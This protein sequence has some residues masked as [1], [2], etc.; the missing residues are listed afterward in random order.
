MTARVASI[1]ALGPLRATCGRAAV[2]ALA[3][4]AACGG[5]GGGSGGGTTLLPPLDPTYRASGKASAGDVFV[6]L[7]EWRWADIARECETFLGPVGYAAVQISP[8]SEHAVITSGVGYP[9]W[10]RYQTVSYKL[11]QS[12]SGTLAEFRDMVSRCNAAGVKIY[13]DAV[14]NHMTAGAGVGSAGSSYTKT[15]YPAVPWSAADFHPGCG[16]NQLRRRRE[17]A[18]VRTRRAGRSAH[19]RRWR[20]Q[21]HRRLPDRLARRRRGGV[22]HRRGQAH[23]AARHRRDRCPS[24]RGSVGRDPRARLALLLSRGDQQRRRGSDRAAV[25]RR[26]LRVGRGC[27]RDRLPVRLPHHRRLHRTRR[28]DARVAANADE[29]PAAE[30]QGRRLRRQPRQPARREPV[31]RIDRRSAF[32]S[33]TSRL[34]SCSRIRTAHRA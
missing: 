14:I 10:Q 2:C 19:R 24:Q 33:T 17:R 18:V 26:R 7:F 30:R 11:D 21:P 28:R 34:C 6:H 31:L 5:G 3:L 4:L 25:L 20:A 22:S 15:S 1:A 8:P 12:R 32:P 13:A 29:R 9:W 16:V 27:R 23:A